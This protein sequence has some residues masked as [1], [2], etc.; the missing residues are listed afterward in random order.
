MRVAGGITSGSLIQAGGLE[1]VFVSG[2]DL[3][4]DTGMSY[5]SIISSGGEQ[6]VSSGALAS[7]TLINGGIEMVSGKAVGDTVHSGVLQL[8]YGSATGTVLDQGGF[9]D[10]FGVASGTVLHSG[11]SEVVRGGTSVQTVIGAGATE[12]VIVGT[13]SG[14]I[15]SDGGTLLLEEG[16]LASGG[17]Y[18]A[19]THDSLEIKGSTLPSATIFGF[20]ATDRIDLEAYGFC[21]GAAASLG[22]NNVLT[23]TGLKGGTATLALDPKAAYA[24]KLFKLAA[25]G[26][27]GTVVTIQAASALQADNDGYSLPENTRLSVDV[28]H[29]VLVN[30]VDP[31]NHVLSAALVGGP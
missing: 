3:T 31:T 25:D 9:Q 22:K 28:R 24:G 6:D 4:K 11:A 13:A 10:D 5:G 21:S 15:I 18:L 30:D 29:G 8:L 19:G 20:A 14:S 16:S 17:I 27:G 2:S 12:D 7:A 23:I 26:Q 1:K